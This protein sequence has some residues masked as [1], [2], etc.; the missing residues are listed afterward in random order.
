[1]AT[2]PAAH[3]LAVICAS[4]VTPAR[5]ASYD[6]TVKTG[7]GRYG[8]LSAIWCRADIRAVQSWQLAAGML[9]ESRCR[10]PL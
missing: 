9:D 6:S 10:L 5:P 7:T 4:I 3:D 1:M 8:I 2:L